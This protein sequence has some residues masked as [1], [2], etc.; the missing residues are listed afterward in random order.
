MNVNYQVVDL[1]L[2]GAERSGGHRRRSACQRVSGATDRV[3]LSHVLV[4]ARTLRAAE[5]GAEKGAEGVECLPFVGA[6]QGAGQCDPI[7]C[8]C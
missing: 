6:R 7:V 4:Q 1:H 2:R 3:A 5:I 8:T